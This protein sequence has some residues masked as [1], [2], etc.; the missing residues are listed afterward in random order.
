MMKVDFIARMSSM[1]KQKPYK[2]VSSNLNKY[3]DDEVKKL[4]K[5]LRLT[6]LPADSIDM[7]TLADFIES[8]VAVDE[9]ID[10]IVLDYDSN[11]QNLDENNMFAQGRVVY[12][13]MAKLARPEGRPFRLCMIASQPKVAFWGDAE[14]PKSCASESSGKQAVVDI[15]ITIGRDYTIPD[16]HAGYMT[17]AKMRRGDE[18][19]KTPYKK[20]PYGFLRELETS[21]YIHMKLHDGS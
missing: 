15:M 9:D 18:G 21:E 4:T 1:V 2:I 13:R 10:V 11:L 8:E 3:F 7:Q 6:V 14:L 19:V 16:R 5:N 20:M 17:I 12:N